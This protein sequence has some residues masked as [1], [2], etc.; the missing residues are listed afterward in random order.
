MK[1]ARAPKVLA[2]QT[3][4]VILVFKCVKQVSFTRV[5]YIISVILKLIQEISVY[6]ISLNM[7]QTGNYL[8][9]LRKHSVIKIFIPNH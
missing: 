9:K 5:T 1:N 3:L 2:T 8:V 6:C 7:I 4:Y